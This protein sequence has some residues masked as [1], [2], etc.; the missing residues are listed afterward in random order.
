M[1][2]LTRTYMVAIEDYDHMIKMDKN[3]NS[4]KLTHLLPM[5]SLDLRNPLLYIYLYF[6]KINNLS[7]CTH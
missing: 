1:Q 3:V 5:F 2:T 4:M 6:K 7:R